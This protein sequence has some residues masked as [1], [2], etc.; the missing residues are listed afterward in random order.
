M[1]SLWL[2]DIRPAPEGWH[3]VL[4]VDEAIQVMSLNNVQRAS[5]DHDLG[6]CDGCY[7]KAGIDPR[8]KNRV[9]QWLEKSAYTEM[10]NCVHLGTGYDLCLWMAEK[11]IWPAE[12]PMVHSAN[13]VGRQRMRGVIDRY[14]PEA[15]NGEENTRLEG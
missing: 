6:S 10:P 1:I 9:E 3:H 14:F 5:L 2:D 8:A 7:A 15:E 4:T 12:K 13:P 11:G